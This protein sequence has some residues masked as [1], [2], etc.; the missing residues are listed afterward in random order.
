MRNHLLISRS[1]RD[2]MRNTATGNVADQLK[3]SM[4]NCHAKSNEARSCW[5]GD[6]EGQDASPNVLVSA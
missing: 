4:S 2:A 5:L 3:P 6:V 1:L